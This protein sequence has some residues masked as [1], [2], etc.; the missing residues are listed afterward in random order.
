MREAASERRAC[1]HRGVQ[2]PGTKISINAPKRNDQSSSVI[3]QP[4]S[5]HRYGLEWRSGHFQPE[6]PM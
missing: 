3:T 5:G 1:S 6:V 2:H 4:A